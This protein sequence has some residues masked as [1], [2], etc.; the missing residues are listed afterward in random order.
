VQRQNVAAWY[1]CENQT[2]WINLGAYLYGTPAGC[3]DQTVSNL[4]FILRSASGFLR[5]DGRAMGSLLLTVE[6]IHAYGN[7]KADV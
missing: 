6:Q 5:D 4:I 2:L 1:V 3:A 7:S